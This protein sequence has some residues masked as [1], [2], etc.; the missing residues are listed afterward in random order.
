MQSQ[1]K[2]ILIFMKLFG[3]GP[4][5]KLWTRLLWPC[6][7]FQFVHEHVHELVQIQLVQ[8]LFKFSSK[9]VQMHF[10][11]FCSISVNFLNMFMNSSWT[12]KTGSTVGENIQIYLDFFE[13]V[14]NRF[15]NTWT[16]FELGFCSNFF[17]TNL[18]WRH[19]L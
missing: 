1:F 18:T 9:V 17:N 2:F 10:S 16:H 12:F 14:Q 8:V 3:N 15:L 5:T 19:W 13:H 4:K 6:F 7:Q 11:K